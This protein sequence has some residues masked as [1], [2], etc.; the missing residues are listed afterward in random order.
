MGPLAILMPSKW[1]SVGNYFVGVGIPVIR[2]LIDLA[3]DPM[4][5]MAI[6]WW[7]KAGP[8][9][10]ATI[11]IFHRPE[12]IKEAEY[13]RDELENQVTKSASTSKWAF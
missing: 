2:K 10:K 11:E 12:H 8:I 6:G 7:D 9:V 1:L 13:L 4:P 5:N 3:Y